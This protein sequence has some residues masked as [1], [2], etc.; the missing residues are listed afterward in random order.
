MFG[1]TFTLFKMFGFAVRIDLSWLIILVLVV[2]SLSA[3]VFPHWYEDLHWGT[4]LGMGFAAALGLFASIV[5]HELCHSLVARR[6]GLKMEGITLFLFGGVAE[7]GDEPESPKV[8]F[9][10]AVAGPIASILVSAVFFSAYYT[11]L[12]LDW[13]MTVTGVLWWVGFI[14]AVLAAFNLIPG[15]P[16]DGGRVL[17]SVI[18]HYT[19]NLR[20]AT[21]SASRAG[22]AFGMTLIVLGF[23]FLLMGNLIGGLWWILIGMFLRS[24]AQQGLQQVIIRELLH[25]DTVS[26][27]MNEAP[28]SVPPTI[29]VEELVEDYVY[30]HHFKMFPVVDGDMLSGC[31]ST[32]EIKN[33][34]REQWNQM[35]V[36]DAMTSCAA[37][38]TVSPDAD[39]MDALR[40]MSKTGIS[41]MMVVDDGRLVGIIALKDLLQFL[42]LKLELESDVPVKLPTPPTATAVEGED[43]G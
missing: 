38:N 33:L 12:A 39:A 11:G 28:V 16:L 4:Y 1:R 14:N 22:A 29:S 6:Y 25:G 20:K 42:S 43:A 27:F 13:T 23:L 30:K 40:K 36:A 8:E 37:D 32:K 24:A 31:I 18:W 10:M 7:M 34:P 5:F 2:W 15:F 21:E 41:R 26:S 19:Q 9:L 3:G 35:T 17:R